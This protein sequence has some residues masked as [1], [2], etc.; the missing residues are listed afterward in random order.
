MSVMET[1]IN[2]RI[3]DKRIQ[4][5]TSQTFRYTILLNK[6]VIRHIICSKVYFINIYIYMIKSTYTR[7]TSFLLSLI[8][9]SMDDSG[10]LKEEEI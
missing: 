7:C 1:E 5:L 8:L 6:Y 4:H 10:V 2:E 3:N 9:V